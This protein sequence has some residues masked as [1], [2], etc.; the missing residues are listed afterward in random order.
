MPTLKEAL[1]SKLSKKELEYV[2]RSFDTVGDIAIF[3]D[4][5]KELEK[6]EKLVAETL[7]AMHKNIKVVAKK[8][9]LHSGEYR[10]PKIKIIAGEKRKTTIHKESG[11]QIKINPEKSYFSP[12]SSE[13][14]LRISKLV[15]PGET[16]LVMFSGAAPYP[17]VLSKNTQAKEI[18]AIELNKEAH[19]LALENLKLNKIENVKLFNGDVRKILPK[20]RKRFDR[21]IMPLPRTASD[22]LDLAFKKIKPKGMVHLY[23]FAA[24]E[25]IPS[26]SIEKIK[27]FKR[28]FKITNVSKCGQFAPHIFRI[29][30]DIKI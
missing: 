13:E 12:R 20:L 16:I 24:E 7:L 28:K 8:T 27:K 19:N 30:I 11:I 6:K 10:T 4:F 14:R 1:K 5:P 9:A 18:Y 25:D 15:Q 26:T 21:I 22:F 3:I 2:P 17:L 29:C 23:D